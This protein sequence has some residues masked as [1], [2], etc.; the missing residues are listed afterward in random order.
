MAACH[1]ESLAELLNPV[2]DRDMRTFGADPAENALDLV[3]AHTTVVEDNGKLNDERIG[4]V[5]LEDVE[6]FERVL[7]F[8]KVQ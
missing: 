7:Q 2:P 5:A 3:E 1:R 4:A 6:F 8:R